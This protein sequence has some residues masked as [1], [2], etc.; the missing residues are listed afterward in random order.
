MRLRSA[1][2]L[3]TN[4]QNSSP[5]FAAA[6]L[7]ALVI[8]RS[9]STTQKEF[10]LCAP[11]MSSSANLSSNPPSGSSSAEAARRGPP[12]VQDKS[13]ELQMQR[14]QAAQ[15]LPAFRDVNDIPVEYRLTQQIK[16]EAGAF[17]GCFLC[18]I[19]LKLT[20]MRMFRIFAL[21]FSNAER[22]PWDSIKISANFSFLQRQG[23]SINKRLAG[24]WFVP[25]F[26]HL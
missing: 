17:S 16:D 26:R 7:C 9:I 20:L 14:L 18:T 8:Q 1:K 2:K 24:L 3:P 6:L 5:P 4:F 13:V 23:E 10:E 11:T 15:R 25:I 12:R 22:W 19:C 21:N